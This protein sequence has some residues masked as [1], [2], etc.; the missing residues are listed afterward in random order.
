MPGGRQ[1]PL[2]RLPASS[3]PAAGRR[4]PSGHIPHSHP[5]ACPAA[6]SHHI[7]HPCLIILLMLP[8]SASASVVQASPSRAGF[9]CIV[10]R[11]PRA[12]GT[13]NLVCCHRAR[14]PRRHA[15]LCSRPCLLP[16]HPSASCTLQRDRHHPPWQPRLQSH[17]APAIP[18]QPL[19]PRPPRTLR[20]HAQPRRLPPVLCAEAGILHAR[21]HL[22]LRTTAQLQHC[23]A[24]V[25]G[26]LLQGQGHIS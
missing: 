10:R 3:Y 15:G 22:P 25:Q 4:D 6:N 5:P 24:K 8:C 19:V 7:A 12:G 23:A 11:R 14:I 1:H 13:A 26:H 9:C 17:A 16:T 2:R 20:R 18:A 21:P